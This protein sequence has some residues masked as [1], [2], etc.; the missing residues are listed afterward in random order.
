MEEGRWVLLI[1][2]E[3][4]GTDSV[5]DRAMERLVDAISKEGYEVVRTATPE[6]GLSLVQ[7]DPSH[8]AIL[9]DWDLPGEHQFE[10]NA[11]LTII[12]EVRHRNKKVPIFL[13]ADRTLVSE[14]PLEVIKQVHEYIHLFADTPA[15]IAN[16]VDFAAERYHE[17]LLPPYFR[18]LKKYT[19]EGAYSWDAPGH[20]GGVAFLKHPV[21][22]EF[23]R[24]F[25]EN[26]LGSGLDRLG[27]PGESERNA[28]RIFGSDWTFYVLAGSST[29][30]RIVGQ[31][32]IGQD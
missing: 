29:S 22:M 11:A 12:R 13:I 9:L 7:S 14:L 17:L 30:N 1:A 10:E 24:F 4:G 3:A 31:G 25:G 23:H 15:F 26:P 20:M 28:A 32:V 18:M 16:R 2:S 19:D 27:P 8:S 6:D 5:A 21:G